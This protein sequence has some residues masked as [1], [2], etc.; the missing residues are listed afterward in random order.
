MQAAT[1]AA[2]ADQALG[3][4]ARLRDGSGL[5]GAPPSSRRRPASRPWAALSSICVPSAHAARRRPPARRR[6]RAGARAGPGGVPVQ[7]SRA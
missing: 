4:P 7:G 2:A 3:A 6:R 5:R 1:Q